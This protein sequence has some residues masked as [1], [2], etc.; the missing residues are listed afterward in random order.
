M[1]VVSL[2]PDVLVATSRIWQTTCTIVRGSVA[3]AKPDTGAAG[4]SGPL[5]VHVSEG[6]PGAG[7]ETF[8]IDS[9]VLPD[10]LEDPAGSTRASTLPRAKRTAGDPR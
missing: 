2:H 7:A 10:E 3:P 5:T 1:R 9:P 6:A 4:T 8:A